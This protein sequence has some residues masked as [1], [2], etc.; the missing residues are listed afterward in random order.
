[1]TTLKLIVNKLIPA[2]ILLLAFAACS[3]EH[4]DDSSEQSEL[5]SSK[6]L[7][8]DF[9]G[10]PRL[11]L[12]ERTR[13]AGQVLLAGS[14][15][16]RLEDL[17]DPEGVLQ[18]VVGVVRARPTLRISHEPLTDELLMINSIVADDHSEG[19]DIGE[20]AARRIFEDTVARLARDGMDDMKGLDLSRV[21][22]SRLRQASGLAGRADTLRQSLKAYVFSA[23]RTVNGL[24]VLHSN[25]T[26]GVHR[27]GKLASIHS[28][29]ALPGVTPSDP[30]LASPRARAQ[31]A[32]EILQRAQVEFPDAHIQGLGLVYA[33]DGQTS[34]AAVEPREVFVVYPRLGDGSSYG[35][36]RAIAYSVT[37]PSAPVAY[38]DTQLKNDRGDIRP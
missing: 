8:M 13:I 14:P 36:G 28:R 37:D 15:D 6:V 26:I 3:D 21:K 1:M 25:V 19:I 20:A 31:S 4:I 10:R 22:V 5:E 24:E 34:A 9:T 38:L 7:P 29:G 2:M 33:L 18:T 30:A 17:R 32:A 16:T 23:P 11:A 27:S 12:A 35:R